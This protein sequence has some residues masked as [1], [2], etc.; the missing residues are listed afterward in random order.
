M[1]TRSEV[2]KIAKK[3][4]GVKQGTKKHKELVDMFNSVKPHGEKGNYSCAWCAITW[5]A[6][7]IIAGNGQKVVPYSYNCGK[8]IEY[9]KKL[10]IWVEE[11]DFI[12][13]PADGIIYYWNDSGKGDCKSGASHVGTVEKIDM[14]KKKITVIEGNKGTTH[15]C[16]RREIGFNSRYIRGFIHPVYDGEAKPKKTKTKKS[17]QKKKTSGFTVGEKYTVTAESGLNIRKGAG[18]NMGIV[19]AA[20]KGTKVECLEVRNGWIKVNYKGV[21]GFMSGEYLK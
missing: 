6:I 12:P 11:D 17:T 20:P 13:S 9:A 2:V 16:G 7:Q 3:Y 19:G 8:L 1:S 18:T 10:G 4:V 14:K 15:A 21:T 5:T